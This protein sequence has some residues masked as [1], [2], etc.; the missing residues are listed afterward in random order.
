[1][2]LYKEGSFACLCS[3]SMDVVS[4]VLTNEFAIEDSSVLI[5]EDGFLQCTDFQDINVY[6]V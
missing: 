3:S 2:I 5:S 4:F 6:S 1:M